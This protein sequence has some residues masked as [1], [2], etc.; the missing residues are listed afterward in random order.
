M[1]ATHKN[2]S[3]DTGQGE[4]TE[5]YA[6]VVAT[7]GESIDIVLH[8]IAAAQAEQIAAQKNREMD[9]KTSVHAVSEKQ[10]EKAHQHLQRLLTS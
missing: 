2:G 8:G 5:R 6:V 9:R 1:T 4:K 7:K 10:V 3:G